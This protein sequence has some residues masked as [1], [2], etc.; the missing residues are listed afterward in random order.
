MTYSRDPA[1]KALRCA[2]ALNALLKD[3]DRVDE[4]EA[5]LRSHLGHGWSL[6]SAAA[7]LTGKAARLAV[8]RREAQLSAQTITDYER[9]VD[10]AVWL[11]AAPDTPAPWSGSQ[12]VKSLRQRMKLL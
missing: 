7:Y 1:E 3:G 8:A 4:I 6:V 2:D 12:H 5:V 11:C 9:A 10:L